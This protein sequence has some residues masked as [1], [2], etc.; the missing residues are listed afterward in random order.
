MNL[1]LYLL[2]VQ[3]EKFYQQK[4]VMGM[5]TVCKAFRQFKGCMGAEYSTCMIPSYFAT[6][7]VPILQSYQ[8][9][10]IF[11]QMHFVC[12]A[13]LQIYLNNE[14]CMSQAWS[15]ETG[16]MLNACRY[17]F[18]MS[19]NAATSSQDVFLNASDG[20]A[21]AIVTIRCV[22]VM[23]FHLCSLANTYTSCFEQ[24]FQQ[25]CGTSSRDSQF[26]GCEYARVNIFTRYPQ[27]DV[28]CVC[29][30]TFFIYK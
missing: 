22:I 5:R 24:Q 16:N 10:S 30:S 11:N 15:G 29:E 2:L 6:A 18:E 27:C 1:M 23:S 17:K 26:W 14:A 13:G 7:S 20:R 12:G 28:S 19:S 3:I 21:N 4:G 25:S 8:F 9:V